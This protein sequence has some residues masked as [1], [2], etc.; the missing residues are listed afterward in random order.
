[1]IVMA[2][3]PRSTR[4]PPPAFAGA[5][6]VL[7]ARLDAYIEVDGAAQR[8]WLA[9]FIDPAAE[10]GLGLVQSAHRGDLPL[11]DGYRLALSAAAGPPSRILCRD[12]ESAAALRAAV[13]PDIAVEVDQGLRLAALAER[14]CAQAASDLGVGS[15]LLAAPALHRDLPGFRAAA[16]ALHAA[17]REAAPPRPIALRIERPREPATMVIL[18]PGGHL[19]LGDPDLD[20]AAFDAPDAPRPAHGMLAFLTREDLGAAGWRL[21]DRSGWL[22]DGERAPDLFL[23][24]DDGVLRPL[25][26]RDVARAHALARAVADWLGAGRPDD[27]AVDLPADGDLAAVV[28]RVRRV[29]RSP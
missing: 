15:S 4:K 16:A 13:P 23:A 14:L 27:R 21:A 19:V 9:F 2:G 7:I 18:T 3:K 12:A 10:S 22:I 5:W 1:M 6:A 29:D 26:D 17:A 8:P 28:A 20:L 24:D 25:T 11:S